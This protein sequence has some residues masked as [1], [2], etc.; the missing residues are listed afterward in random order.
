MTTWFSATAVTPQL[1]THLSLGS[2][3]ASWL[4]NAVQ[5]GFVMGALGLSL[6]GLADRVRLHGVMAAGAM[7]AATANLALLWAPDAASAL[8]SR[9]A[10][11]VALAA[12]YPPALKLIA[13]WHRSG[14]GLALGAAIAALTVGSAF[15]HL[16]RALAAGLDWR[17]VVAGASGMTLLGAALIA[18]FVREGPYRFDK[19]PFSAG[20]IVDVLRDRGLFLTNLGYFGHMWELY[21]MWS[22]FL[23]YASEAMPHGR[24]PHAPFPSLVTFAVVAVGGLGCL[25]GGVLADRCGR[26]LTTAGMM[27]ASGTCALLI[28]FTFDGP[29]WLFLLVAGVWGISIV[30][31]SAQFSAI[32]TEIGDP[33]LVGTA[34][35]LQLGIGFALT[36]IAIDLL[37]M[38]AG[39]IGWRWS[40]LVLVP[41]PVFGA[42]A[43]L[44]LRATPEAERIAGGLR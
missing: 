15:P 40:F 23:A 18:S 3:Q 10:T 36:V 24:V 44:L 31:D 25:L 20:R 35:A 37:P 5:I 33:P 7:L 13:T 41:G 14:R 11:G 22:W 27:A 43:M 16:L 12:V 34:L 6:S 19:A 42:I 30:G 38:V 17:M 1:V 9:F 21:A 32:V 28:G 8:L 2:A 39:A 29:E 26:T 4:T